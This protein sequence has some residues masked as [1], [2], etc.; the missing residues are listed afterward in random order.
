MNGKMK[1]I[2]FNVALM[3]V[4]IVVAAALGSQAPSWYTQWK[5]PA[6]KGDYSVHVAGQSHKITLY[7]TTTC[8]YCKKARAWLGARNI[9]YNDVL[10][11][12]SA[13]AQKRYGTLGTDAVPVLVS[14]T[15]LLVGFKE[16][17]YKQFLR[18]LN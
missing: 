7:G 17:E 6:V 8:S 11:D 16:Q 5:G 15:H 10:V 14:E 12:E 3:A 4:T 2:A 13:E 9:A 18:A 1:S